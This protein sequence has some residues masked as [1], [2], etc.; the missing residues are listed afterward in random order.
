[1][2]YFK[3]LPLDWLQVFQCRIF[4]DIFWSQIYLFINMFVKKFGWL[5]KKKV[6]LFL[7]YLGSRNTQAPYI[8]LKLNLHKSFSVLLW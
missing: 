2:M 8:H 7:S 3:Q 5:V 4:F 1:M 6:V